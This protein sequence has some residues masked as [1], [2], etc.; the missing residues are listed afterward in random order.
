MSK[1]QDFIRIFGSEGCQ[2]L[3]EIKNQTAEIIIILAYMIY[4]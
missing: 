2:R 1:F 4:N 3:F